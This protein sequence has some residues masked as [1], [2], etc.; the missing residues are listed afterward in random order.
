MRLFFIVHF[1]I[2]VGRSDQGDG[3]KAGSVKGHHC[4]GQKDQHESRER[5]GVYNG[6]DRP[7][8]ILGCTVDSHYV[9]PAVYLQAK[10]VIAQ[11]Q[12]TDE[13]AA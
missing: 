9:Q 3:V 4:H 5:Q 1:F 12:E 6:D 11:D 13:G 8:K 10:A 2:A 7:V